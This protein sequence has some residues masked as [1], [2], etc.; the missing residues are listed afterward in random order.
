YDM[1]NISRITMD[2]GAIAPDRLAIFTTQGVLDNEMRWPGPKAGFRIDQSAGSFSFNRTFLR[3]ETGELP[4]GT[5]AFASISHTSANS[6][7]GPGTSPGKRLNGE[8]GFTQKISKDLTVRLYAA[9]NEMDEN[10]YYSLGYAQAANPNTYYHLGFNPSLTGVAAQDINY[11]Q[12][13]RQQFRNTAVFGEIA[14][15]PAPH[16]RF[17]FKPFYTKEKGYYLYGAAAAPGT[18]APGVVNWDID[19]KGYGFVASGETEWSGTQFKA[20][21]WFEDL[22][23]PGPPT[24]W[25]TYS[26][27]PGGSLVFSKWAILAQPASDHR[28]SSPFVKLGRNFG[29]LH[30]TMGVRYMMEETPSIVDYNTAGIGDMSYAAAIAS[31]KSVNSGNSV[32]GRTLSA[33]LPYFGLDYRI[34]PGTHAVFS[35]GRNFGAPAF[36]QWPTLVMHGATLAAKG[37]TVQQLWNGMQ[38]ETSSSFD[39]GLKLRRAA[40]TL[41]PGIFY[42]SYRN[43][44]VSVYDPALGFG[45]AQNV[46]R[47]HSYGLEISGNAEAKPGLDLFG[48]VTLMRSVLDQ[49]FQGLSGTMVYANGN[50][51]PDAPKMI[52]NFGARQRFGSFYVAPRI[53]WMGMRY[54]DSQN[55]Q[56]VGGYFLANLDMG[57]ATKIPG[58]GKLEARIGIDNL[59]NRHYIGMIDAAYLQDPNGIRFYAGAPLTVSA[60]V[61]LRY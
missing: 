8:I 10:N 29:D 60:T 17:T 13:N 1:E 41:Q 33:W 51:I 46:G 26:F 49:N 25:K 32:S 53:T 19:H 31:A 35:W 54:A 38:A 52:L 12:Y 39:L 23:P 57:Y 50:Q 4:S 36:N 3:A 48:S 45:Y 56:P 21:Y 20:G 47:S 40:W 16:T 61:S 14:Y 7:Q 34:D 6:W 42:S 5:R 22:Q 44:L 59:F 58:A 18:N 24:G 55:Q 11:F 2:E 27:G 9:Q 30:A 15:Q 43:K 37:I 28:I